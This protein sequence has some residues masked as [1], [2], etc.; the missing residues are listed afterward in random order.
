MVKNRMNRR[1]S[2][3]SL[4]EWTKELEERKKNYIKIATNI[5][6]RLTNEMLENVKDVSSPHGNKPFKDTVKIPARV[7]ESG[8]VVEAGI[9]NDHDEA[10]FNEYGTGIVG[11][12]NPHIAEELAKI[13]YKYD[14]N[15]YGDGGWWYPTTADDPNPYK[16]IDEDG[17][18]RGWT[19]GL[20]A[21]KAFYNALRK[22][23]ERFKEV[24]K[25]ELE[26]EV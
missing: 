7:R 9:R 6:N 14:K 13:G 16:W 18:L 17:Q 1:L 3:S 21:T 5:A 10:Y 19:A 22:A 12:D 2:L 26:K 24:G 11:C 8:Y 25:E 15:N 4:D 23:E 20:P